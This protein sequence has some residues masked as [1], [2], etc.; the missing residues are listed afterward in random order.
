MA[1]RVETSY[2]QCRWDENGI[3][4]ARGLSSSH[5]FLSD[6]FESETPW[7]LLDLVVVERVGIVGNGCTLG[8][9]SYPS[10]L[11]TNLR[12]AGPR[13]HRQTGLA[14]SNTG[15]DT[16]DQYALPDQVPEG[17]GS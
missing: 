1:S 11:R 8:P 4:Q 10:S 12:L 3:V 9:K 13:I 5:Q 17:A 14:R 2:A 15:S 7:V 6:Y 16:C